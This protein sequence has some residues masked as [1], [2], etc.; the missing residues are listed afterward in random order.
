MF[1]RFGRTLAIP[2]LRRLVSSTAISQLGDRLTHMLLISLIALSR[3][4]SLLGY[5]Q[6]A[7]AFA[8]PTLLL[9]PFVGVLVDRW[10][11]RRVLA[12]THFVQSGLL[13]VTPLLIAFSGSFVPFWVALFL[14]F[15]LDVFNNTAH[16]ALL[17][18]LVPED[19]ILAANSVNLTFARV[20]TVVGM[21]V[22]GYLIRWVGWRTGLL[23]DASTHLVAGLFA[24]SIATRLAGEPEGPVR[25][26]IRTAL[27]RF[28]AELREVLRLVGR[29]RLVALVLG[30]IVASTFVS[31][32]AYTVLIFLV[33][34]KLGL[35]TA[36]VGIFTGIVAVG[37]I[38]GAASMSAMPQ[39][40][41]R[42][43]VV[44]GV[45]TLFGALFV[46]GWFHVSI[47][48]LAVVALVVGIA[49][50]WLG[51]V[52]NTIL[53]EQV[54]PGIRGRIFS[55]HTFITNATFIATTL[56]VGA[57]GELTSYR[58]VFPVAGLV[59]VA[60]GAAGFLFVRRTSGLRPA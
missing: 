60:A 57:L 15:G 18:A 11:K 32:V 19:R 10:D 4:G 21:V 34:Q 9:S 33:Q 54:S 30:S 35:G 13:L 1:G 39:N 5:S 46:A 25:G 47:P 55:T 43:L 2:D 53:Q 20:A 28:F 51:V 36:G 42:P 44:V 29:N 7:M 26:E 31:A 27:P 45:V 3:P 59:L 37:M 41:N 17:P 49:F 52:Q 56:L 50:S 24:L 6:G 16:P 8:L 14:F 23:I 38:A 12:L 48:F 58:V 40:V 22:G